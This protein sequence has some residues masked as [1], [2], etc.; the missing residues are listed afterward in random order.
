MIYLILYKDKD[1]KK[2]LV[3]SGGSL[4]ALVSEN[5]DEDF[6]AGFRQF[7]GGGGSAELIPVEGD[8]SLT[9]FDT[10][11]YEEIAYSMMFSRIPV[12]LTV[13][14]QG[15]SWAKKIIERMRKNLRLDCSRS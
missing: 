3:T 5:V 15:K 13:K 7:G 14:F 1:S 2:Q 4:F 6:L 9:L 8:G 10:H 11:L 12:T